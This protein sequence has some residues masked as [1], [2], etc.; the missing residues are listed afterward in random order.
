MMTDPIADHLSDATRARWSG[1]GGDYVVTLGPESRA[2]RV[3]GPPAGL[4][5]LA[6]SVNTFTRLWL[7]VSRPS[8][9]PFTRTDLDAP[10][11][12]LETLDRVL[13]VPVPE[14]DWDF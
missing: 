7:G 2:E 3:D 4:E 1:V 12:L 10:P 5:T 6:T 8:A 13:R 9:L 14:P 11:S